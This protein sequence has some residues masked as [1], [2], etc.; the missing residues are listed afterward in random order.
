MQ[1]KP[2][3]RRQA[4]LHLAIIGPAGAGKTYTALRL[5]SALGKK[6]ALIDT[7][8][9]S[10]CA[11]AS[12]FKFDVCELDDHHPNTYI[13]A[14]SMADA[15]GYDVLVIDSLSHA[16]AGRNAALELVD[17]ATQ[18]S[19]SANAFAA[20]RNVTPL[21]NNLLD[22]ML[23]S[24]CHVI[25]T[26][27]AKMAYA[28][29]K[30]S[31]GKTVI[32]KVGLQPLQRDGLEYEFDIVGDIDLE[33][34]L[35]VTKSRCSPL[36]GAVIHKPGEELAEALLRWLDPPGATP[37]PDPEAPLKAWRA[38]LEEVGYSYP[39]VVS[40]LN[41]KGRGEPHAWPQERLEAALNWLISDTGRA[42]FDAWRQQK[43]SA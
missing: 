32:R 43:A 9:S 42:A 26:L 28:Q 35:V 21:H 39:D 37:L 1:F 6:V 33:H 34:N 29:E 14:I 22:A 7:E 20:W 23:S 38:A 17:K 2:A 8:R 15:A 4:R 41:A 12:D 19:K 13:E 3:D 40:F 5:A 24:R 18:R 36:A 16:W 11:Y 10:A 25:A 31:K 30:D 27:R